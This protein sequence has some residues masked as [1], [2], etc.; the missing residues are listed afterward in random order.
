MDDA[1]LEERRARAVAVR[2]GL[3]AEIADRLGGLDPQAIRAVILEAWP[4]TRSA[5][6][7]HDVLLDWVA[8]PRARAKRR[9]SGASLR[10]PRRAGRAARV[11]RMWVT[12]ER[13]AWAALVWGLG[14][15]EGQIERAEQAIARLV[16][17]RLSFAGPVTA[18]ALAQALDLDVSDIEI[19]LARAEGEGAI[20][21]GRFTPA[22][23]PDRGFASERE[24]EVEWCDRRLLAR[25]PP[26]H[27]R[28]RAAPFQLVT[29][30]H[31]QR[32]FFAWQGLRPEPSLHGRAGLLRAIDQLQG[33]E[34]AAGAWERHILP[35][36]VAKYDPAWLDA[37]CLSGEVVWGRLAPREPTGAA[38]RA[39]PHYARSPPGFALALAAH[40]SG[41]APSEAP[42]TPLSI[43]ARAVHG[44]LLASGA[45]FFD[46]IARGVGLERAPCS[47]TRC[48]A[49]RR[50]PRYGR[51]LRG[52]PFALGAALKARLVA[53]NDERSDYG[54][55]R[56]RG[57]Y[58]PLVGASACLRAPRGIPAEMP[59]GAE[60]DAAE[61]GLLALARQYLR[62]LW[63]YAP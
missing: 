49:R 28:R 63:R 9:A 5:D 42:A 29:I 19:G 12:T 24:R 20:L 27:D 55:R 61:A 4:D 32:F 40:V 52:P 3:P 22:P 39:A 60:L 53:A 21:R 10:G 25:D 2:R 17:G 47:K 13:L 43:E 8:L 59:D 54:F 37:L 35:A 31:L 38:P 36:R 62:L 1:P 14:S 56:A 34:L 46:D 30:A 6:E 7:L 51:R 11:G 26:P 48:G 45:S 23:G 15:T 18:A 44:Y 16:R 50:G 41:A 58:R 57:R 33:F